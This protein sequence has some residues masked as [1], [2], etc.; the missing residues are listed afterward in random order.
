MFNSFNL[1]GFPMCQRVDCGQ[2]AM[3]D[4]LEFGNCNLGMKLIGP[5]CCQGAGIGPRGVLPG[6]RASRRLFLI[7]FGYLPIF[8]LK[9]P[10]GAPVKE[11]HEYTH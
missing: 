5:V 11:L 4:V 10:A 2:C 1:V 7:S 6:G 3:M 9:H 8:P